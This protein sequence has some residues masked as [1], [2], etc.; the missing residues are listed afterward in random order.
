MTF[1]V[2]FTVHISKESFNGVESLHTQ[3]S[4]H[5]LTFSSGRS[6]SHCRSNPQRG[7]SFQD[8]SFQ[9]DDGNSLSSDMYK[10]L[11]F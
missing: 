6:V 11:I 10:F 8:S 9:V 3:T 4:L 1:N 2:S 5:H 7:D